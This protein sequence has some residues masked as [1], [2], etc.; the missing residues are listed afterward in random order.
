[1][2]LLMTPLWF[3][4]VAT[5]VALFSG[6]APRLT[7][8]PIS[9]EQPAWDSEGVPLWRD[10][11]F[12]RHDTLVVRHLREQRYYTSLEAGLRSRGD[13]LELQVIEK[14]GR[15]GQEGGRPGGM[16]LQAY[17]ARIAPL[18]PGVYTLLLRDEGFEPLPKPFTMRRL[19]RVT[20]E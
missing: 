9:P 19:I 17:E 13:T 10:T 2:N 20:G 14:A 15:A 16:R 8:Y 7:F 5:T 6:P 1:M 12:V 4:G 3:V 18:I 11:I